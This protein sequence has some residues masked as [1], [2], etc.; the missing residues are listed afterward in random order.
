MFLGKHVCS[1][2][3][4]WFGRVL[5]CVYRVFVLFSRLPPIWI[6][7]LW[8]SIWQLGG[9]SALSLRRW[10]NVLLSCCH[11]L[12]RVG[13]FVSS[14]VMMCLYGFEGCWFGGISTPRQSSRPK[15]N[16]ILLSIFWSYLSHVNS[17]VIIAIKAVGYSTSVCSANPE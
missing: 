16:L 4:L 3:F 17:F 8:Q 1:L 7:I 9:T 5:L 11:V 10:R 14:I 12:C 15:V 6:V 13:K 2:I